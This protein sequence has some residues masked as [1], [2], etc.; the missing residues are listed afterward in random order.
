MAHAYR[1]IAADLLTGTYREEIPFSNI[2]YAHQLN[3]PGTFTGTIGMRHPKAT[4]ANIDPARTLIHVERDGVI[5]WSGILWACRAQ[6]SGPTL[7]CDGEGWW[8]YFKRRL[9][10][11]DKTYTNA[12]PAAVAQD[13]INYAQGVSGGNIGVSVPA[14]SSTAN[15]VTQT[16]KAIDDLNVGTL[17]E[18][19]AAA[20]SGFDFAVDVS[21][22]AG[23]PT[24]VFNCYSPRRGVRMQQVLDLGGNLTAYEQDVDG[25][26]AANQVKLNGSG[27][28]VTALRTVQ[29]D[30]T[31]LVSYPLLE[32]ASSYTNITNLARLNQ[33][34]IS[35]LFQRAA[36][37]VTYPG[38][39]SVSSPDTS[40]GS[41]RTGDSFLIRGSDGYIKASGYQR[42]MS[43]A[44]S[45]DQNGLEQVKLTIVP[46]A[47]SQ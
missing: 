21:Y 30:T 12:D 28:G 18:Q 22:V 19:L 6:V 16:W 29:A 41:F 33:Q 2:T 38:V 4:R 37:V 39:L 35:D 34:A 27:T 10:G 14:T 36:P 11:V 8:S 47:I 15:V 24:P 40:I 7:Q 45:V 43:W 17:V 13:L 26:V 42:V 1:V 46:E 31:Q 23:V 9:L 25:T 32:A 44:V 20:P 5:V 3:A